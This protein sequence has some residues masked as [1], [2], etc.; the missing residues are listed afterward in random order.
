ML[1]VFII[2]ISSIRRVHEHFTYSEAPFSQKELII[3]DQDTRRNMWHA[4]A[5]TTI[6][7]ANDKSRWMIFST[8][9]SSDVIQK[10]LNDVLYDASFPT[11]DDLNNPKI[12]AWKAYKPRMI[13]KHVLD[14]TLGE[15]M[16]RSTLW[17]AFG[18]FIVNYRITHANVSEQ[19]DLLLTFQVIVYKESTVYAKVIEFDMLYRSL[20]STGTGNCLFTRATVIGIIHEQYI[21][22]GAAALETSL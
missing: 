11:V 5:P 15:F 18:Y 7:V 1:I 9:H 17:I 14:E 19:G 6:D 8:G 13:P 20:P 3:T 22:E 16:R 21:Q 2:L 12:F 10:R 4:I